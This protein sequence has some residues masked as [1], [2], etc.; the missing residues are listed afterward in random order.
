[1][2]GMKFADDKYKSFINIYLGYY[3]FKH[4][5]LLEGEQ[6]NNALKEAKRAFEKIPPSSHDYDFAQQH[7]QSINALD[8]GVYSI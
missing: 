2:P 8:R 1:M 4:S 5:R 6:K 3:G 7:I